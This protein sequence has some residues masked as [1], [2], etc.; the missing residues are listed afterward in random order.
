MAR[1]TN[2]AGAPQRGGEQTR[3][4]RWL[5][6]LRESWGDA[7]DNHVLWLLLFVVLGSWM[8]TPHRTL[9]VPSVDVGS[10]ARRDF[11]APEAHLMPDEKATEEKRRAVR[12]EVLP[13]YDFDLTVSEER[14]QQL[15][16]LFESGRAR[17][18][19]EQVAS[20]NSSSDSETEPE[21]PWEDA[22]E[23]A[24]VM[25][26]ND[27]VVDVLRRREFD[28]ELESELGQVFVSLFRRGIVAD[29][30]ELLK[31]SVNG[32]TLRRLNRGVERVER[33]LYDYLDVNEDLERVVSSE[34][35]NLSRLSSRQRAVFKDFFLG[36]LTANVHPNLSETLQRREAATESTAV[37]FTQIRKGQVIVRRGDEVTASQARIIQSLNEEEATGVVLLHWTASLVLLSLAGLVLWLSL[38][39]EESAHKSRSR[40][41]SELLLLLLTALVLA[42]FGF[43][44]SGA[45]SSSLDFEP[46][47]S[48]RSYLYALPL[49]SLAMVIVLLY[50]RQCA[51]LPVL[52]FSVLVARQAGDQGQAALIYTAVGSL[53]ALYVLDR[54]PFKQRSVMLRVG[55]AVGLVNLLSIFMVSVFG[56]SFTSTLQQTGFDALCGLLGGIL[57]APVASFAISICEPLF[58]IAT[59]IRLIELS[60]TNLPLLRRLAMEAPGT[61]QHSLM[62]GNLAK[63]GCDAIGADSVVAYTTALYHDVGK[64]LR[65]EYF[66]ENQRSELNPHDEINPSMSVLILIGHIKDG[67]ELARQYHLPVVILDAIEQHHGTRK[68]TFFYNR[69]LEQHDPSS[70]EVQETKYRYPG[71]KPQDKINGILMLADGIEAASR[72]LTEPTS[73]RQRALVHRIVE[74][75]L[76]D[77]QLDETDLTLSDLHLAQE[78]FVRLLANLSHRRVDYPGFDFNAETTSP[79]ES[80]A[81]DAVTN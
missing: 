30:S 71:P 43:F 59:H 31:N 13:V 66:I 48:M 2:K 24:S 78:A 19:R 7:L 33:D 79:E 81:G 64:V 57:C 73:N 50:G 23:E 62:V 63:A 40:L 47:N 36:N 51:L 69:A 49:A 35:R 68:I 8:V 6:R 22:L 56:G 38:R 52:L 41:F 80:A 18:L 76:Q 15:A 11:V 5:I 61:F 4:T 12:D 39:G 45:L 32:V 21:K 20:D 55:M 28:A 75:C 72:T 3:S 9:V 54:Y 77:G 44:L 42:R 29:K 27:A 60:N 74:D 37:V 25:Q 65:P 70:G 17:L 16:R 67:A 53:T 14:Q 10:I 46:F 26:L 34:I 1:S 58:S